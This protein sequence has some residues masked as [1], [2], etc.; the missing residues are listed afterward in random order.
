[1]N[2][3][4]KIILNNGIPLY[5]CVDPTMKRVFVSYN[6]KY[7]SSGKW[8]N[9]NSNGKDYS[10]TNGHAHFLEHLLGE[11]SKY[12]DMYKNF[13]ERYQKSNAY[14]GMEITSYHFNG[15]HSIEKSIEE[16]ITAID[17]PVF[18]QKDVDASREAIEEESSTYVDD[19]GEN[20]YGLLRR[21]LYGGFELYDETLSPIGN[22]ETTRQI[23]TE[24]LYDCYNAFYTDDKK[25]IVIGGNVDEQ[26]IVDLLNDTYS[27]LPS[28]KSSLVLPDIDFDSIREKS[29]VI[30]GNIDTPKVGLGFKFKNVPNVSQREFCYVLD[31]ISSSLARSNELRALDK[32]GIYDVFELCDTK[33]N[34][35]YIDFTL[36]FTSKEKEN[37]VNSLLDLLSKREITKE[38]YE[39]TRKCLLA[40][41]F[42]S[43]D[44][45]YSF[46]K[47]F[48]HDVSFKE[49]YSNCEF[50]QSID[51][52]RFMEIASKLD[53]SNYTVGEVKR[54]IK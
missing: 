4:K 39:L 26:R 7:G 5:L 31:V 8:F 28:H 10:V 16:L 35:D 48:P 47:S 18:E 43:M 11:H 20:L 12:G 33:V 29:E 23:T 14:T 46:L 22:R 36:G 1:M 24:G 54:L 32:K 53:F 50:Y 19:A 49:E 41:E 17:T 30:N 44:N 21:N 45:K 42:R 40:L 9:F 37:L 25:F 3:F 15:V 52:N 34:G 27:K 51:Y 2:K 13:D 38:E 6:I